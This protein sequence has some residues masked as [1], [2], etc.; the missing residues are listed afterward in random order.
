MGVDLGPEPALKGLDPVAFTNARTPGERTVA[1]ERN[2]YRYLFASDENRKQFEREP[3]RYE[4]QQNGHCGAMPGVKG[5]PDLFAVVRAASTSLARRP[6]GPRSRPNRRSFSPRRTS[7][8]SFTRVELLDFAGPAES[9]P[10]PTAA[11]RSTSTPSRSRKE[12][13][14]ARVPDDQAPVYPANCPKPTSS[15]CPGNTAS[16]P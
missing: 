13:S 11:G 1:L 14:S 3:S 2:G 15:C 8:S 5:D 12:K 16:A 4:I 9:S 7:P 6:V 10:P